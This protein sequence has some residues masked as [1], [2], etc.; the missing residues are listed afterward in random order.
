MRKLI[1][2][3]FLAVLFSAAGAWAGDPAGKGVAAPS[4]GARDKCPVC[5]MFVSKYPDWVASMAD[6]KGKVFFFDG[7]KDLYK[8]YFTP[9]K[10][11]YKENPG[12]WQNI[13]VTDYYD[14]RP[15]AGRTA[16]YVIGSDV[17]GPMGKELIPF[18][19]KEDAQEFLQDHGGTRIISFDEVTRSLVLSMDE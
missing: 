11:G 18:A 16:F 6:Q 4:P 9:E 17:Y 3:I 2:V 7:V 1:F 13:F 5:G 19:K 8:F 12:A 10:Y 15:I 14:I